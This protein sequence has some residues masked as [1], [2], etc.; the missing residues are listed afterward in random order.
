[1]KRAAYSTAIEA[2]RRDC[3]ERGLYWI[4]RQRAGGNGWPPRDI[5]KVC[6]WTVVNM[7]AHLVHE[8]PRKVAAD[9]IDHVE[10]TENGNVESHNE[11]Y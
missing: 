2:M 8:T 10:T 6:G 4:I 5:S 9:L 1:M 7:L 11:P 3:Y